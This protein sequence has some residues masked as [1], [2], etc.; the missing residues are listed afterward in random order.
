MK[1]VDIDTIPAVKAT[2]MKC[3]QVHQ[4]RP[5]YEVKVD[6]RRAGWLVFYRATGC[7]FNRTLAGWSFETDDGSWFAD[8]DWS[9]KTGNTYKVPTPDD[10]WFTADNEHLAPRVSTEF[11]TSEGGIRK[12]RKVLSTLKWVN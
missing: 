11:L 12:A 4:G 7:G 10:E 3:E 9:D 8:R 6:G 2:F 1:S 5:I